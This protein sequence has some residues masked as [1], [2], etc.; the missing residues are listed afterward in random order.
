MAVIKYHSIK[1]DAQG[2]VVDEQ[3]IPIYADAINNRLRRDYNLSDLHSDVEARKNIGLIGDVSDIPNTHTHDRH[4]DE[5]R[6]A[7]RRDNETARANLEARLTETVTKNYIEMSSKIDALEMNFNNLNAATNKRLSIEITDRTDGD[8][9]LSNRLDA[10]NR[11]LNV[12]KLTRIDADANLQRQVDVNKVNIKT[13]KDNLADT[14]SRLAKE[15]QD[16]IDADNRLSKRLEAVNADL[17]SKLNQEETDRI[18]ADDALSRRITTNTN[19]LATETQNRT[20]ADDA[21]SKR[22]TDNAD[23][24][25]N[26]TAKL[27]N[28]EIRITSLEGKSDNHEGRISTLESRSDGIDDSLATETATRIQND[29][30]LSDRIAVL[31]NRF[32]IQPEDPGTKAPQNSI[33]F[34]TKNKLIKFRSGN[35]WVSFGATWL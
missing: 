13:N 25:S 27:N 15:T 32:W 24:I 11:D 29:N 16:R 4:Y 34:D 22:V 2:K 19:N 1:R 3:W 28:H 26:H 17:T 18:D 23:M 10:T 33:W 30:S 20:D 9:E 6:Q 31:E 35:T 8:T 12:E 7:D 21:L 14:D 5:W